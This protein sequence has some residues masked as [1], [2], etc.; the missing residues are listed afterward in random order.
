MR[1]VAL[2]D[3]LARHAL[4][5]AL[6]GG[7]QVPLASFGPEELEL[8]AALRSTRRREWLLSRF[9]AK[10]LAVRLGLCAEPADCTLPTSGERPSLRIGGEASSLA[11]SLSH[12]R[13]FAAAAIDRAAIG[14][15]IEFVRTLDERAAHLFMTDDELTAVRRTPTSDA[16]LHFWCAK[17]AAWKTLSHV[18]PTLKKTPLEITAASSDSMTMVSALGINVVTCRP[19]PSLIVSL[20]RTV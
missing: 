18:F 7:D 19:E 20:A 11:V 15:D 3:A 5:M 1:E 8:A 6:E 9:A 17:E 16:L 14:I 2:P 10:T 4:V 12:S 13:Q